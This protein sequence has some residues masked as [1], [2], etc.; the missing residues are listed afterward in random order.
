MN[1]AENGVDPQVIVDFMQENMKEALDP[2]LRWDGPNANQQ[3]AKNVER[4]GRLMGSRLISFSGPN[5]RLFG[6]VIDDF[7]DDND[8]TDF[9]DFDE[10][11]EEQLDTELVARDPISG[12]PRSMYEETRAMLLAGFTPLHSPV[13]RRKL[14]KICD[15]IIESRREKYHIPIKRS[16]EAFIAPGKDDQNHLMHAQN[17]LTSLQILVMYLRKA[18]YIS[19]ARLQWLKSEICQTPIPSADPS[20]FVVYILSHKLTLIPCR[21]SETH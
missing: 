2:L 1:L 15:L 19:G 10:D 21:S 12:K 7:D 14:E 20:W 18:K 13:V 3:L 17:S 11:S 4:A 8:D 9:D 6:H 5:A 16:V